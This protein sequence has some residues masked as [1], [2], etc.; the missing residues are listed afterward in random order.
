MQTF[1][2]SP[3]SSTATFALP[4][5]ATLSALRKMFP[6]SPSFENTIDWAGSAVGAF[7][8]T[9]SR[10]VL[11]G[12]LGVAGRRNSINATSVTTRSA[13]E[14]RR[15]VETL[16]IRFVRAIRISVIHNFRTAQ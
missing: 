16:A 12:E 7:E 8:T 15:I 10:T 5:P 6:A 1:R 11:G 4:A 14:N 3:S 9:G 13:M 2:A